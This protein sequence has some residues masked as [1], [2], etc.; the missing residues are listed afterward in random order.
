ML[1]TVIPVLCVV[2]LTSADREGKN[3]RVVTKNELQSVGEL[4]NRV[5]ELEDENAR[6]QRLVDVDFPNGTLAQ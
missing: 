1:I 2:Q 5:F 6:M 3:L 4:K